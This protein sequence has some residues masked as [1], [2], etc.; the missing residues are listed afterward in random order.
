M[1]IFS[2]M[3]KIMCT[4]AHSNRRDVVP[5]LK[6]VIGSTSMSFFSLKAE[7]KGGQ[8]MALQ[9]TFFFLHSF[10]AV[11]KA[12]RGALGKPPHHIEKSWRP[13]MWSETYPNPFIWGI[14]WWRVS[15]LNHSTIWGRQWNN[16][17]ASWFSRE[18]LSLK[19]LRIS[20]DGIYGTVVK[21]TRLPTKNWIKR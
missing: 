13:F 15:A 9:V 21:A 18:K 10:R 16:L 14:W 12:N 8:G 3:W 7:V 4:P 2:T 11:G 1:G 6:K 19:P 20:E 17:F 5:D